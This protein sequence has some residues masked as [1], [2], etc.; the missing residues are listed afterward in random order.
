M[1][2]FKVHAKKFSFSGL[3]CQLRTRCTI[4]ASTNPKGKYDPE[5]PLSVNVGIA[6]PL[7]S[8]F[9]LVYLLLDSKNPSWDKKVS[10]YIL[11]NEDPMKEMMKGSAASESLWSFS[12]MQSY[13]C[14]CKQFNPK[15]G[16]A[17]SR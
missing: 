16:S 15:I 9:D 13:F 11:K 17:A 7:L 8:R 2:F 6:S 4:L 5:E 3:V 14:Y 12:K 1:F 10:T